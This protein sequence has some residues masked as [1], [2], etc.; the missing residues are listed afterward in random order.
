[1]WKQIGA[2]AKQNAVKFNLTILGSGTSQGVPI[3]AADYSPEFLAN[4]KT[5]GRVRRCTSRRMKS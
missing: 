4:P 1:M 2:D 5:T 3:I